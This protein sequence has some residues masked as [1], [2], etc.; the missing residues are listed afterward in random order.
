MAIYQPLTAERR[1]ALTERIGHTLNGTK[2]VAAPVLAST[3]TGAVGGELAKRDR[4]T[5]AEVIARK[6]WMRAACEY[7]EKYTGDFSF[8]IDMRTAM[9]RNGGLSVAQMRGTLNCMRAEAIRIVEN[10]KRAAATP[11]V[12]PQPSETV[13]YNEILDG[14]YTVAFEDGSHVTI[15]VNSLSPKQSRDGKRHQF[16]SYLCGPINTSD[17]RRF[18]EIKG[19]TFRVFS[20]YGQN[21]A[22]QITALKIL[23]GSDNQ[24]QYGKA[25]AKMATRC[26]R[27]G[28]LLTEPESI[29]SGI[30]PICAGRE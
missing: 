30:G 22:R 16:A 23:M 13:A 18:A 19:A 8:M 6:D 15:R 10:A 25:Y 2:P 9:K 1:A 17:Y 26:Y 12:Q 4:V 21:Y 29:E 5:D 24:T 3:A 14:Y 11:V 27:C 7:A 28:K 20:M